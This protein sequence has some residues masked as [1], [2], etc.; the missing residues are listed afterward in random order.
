M[1]EE[2]EIKVKTCNKCGV[3][4]TLDQFSK[5][6]AESDGHQRR[7]KLCFS[8]AGKAAASAEPVNPSI[9]SFEEWVSTDEKFPRLSKEL[10]ES[11]KDIYKLFVKLGVMY[12]PVNK[13]TPEQRAAYERAIQ[14]RKKQ[15]E[16]SEACR[17]AEIEFERANGPAPWHGDEGYRPWLYAKNAAMQAAKNSVKTVQSEQ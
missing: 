15:A 14:E 9:M 10:Q 11:R 5:S 13:M 17:L 4:K 6:K 12:P 3:G 7:C 16:I 1:S 2:I 8:K